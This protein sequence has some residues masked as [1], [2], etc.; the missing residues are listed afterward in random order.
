MVGIPTTK[1][2]SQV[3]SEILLVLSSQMKNIFD[4]MML[5][6]HVTIMT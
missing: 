5:F 2:K 1:Q 6:S 3:L 4:K